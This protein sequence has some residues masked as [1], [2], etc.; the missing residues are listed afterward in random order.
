MMEDRNDSSVDTVVNRPLKRSSDKQ[1]IRIDRGLDE[2]DIAG[3]HQSVHNLRR[4]WRI[5]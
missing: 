2:R 5:S 1:Y 4:Q 3:T